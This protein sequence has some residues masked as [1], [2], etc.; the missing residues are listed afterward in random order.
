M[1]EEQRAF[2]AL[3]PEPDS[4]RQCADRRRMTCQVPDTYPDILVSDRG[5]ASLAV[6]VGGAN[7]ACG[8]SRTSY[9]VSTKVYPVQVV[10]FRIH[11]SAMIGAR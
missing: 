7:T 8:R 3:A 6:D 1:P 9:E 5:A 10:L 11:V 2:R 4:V